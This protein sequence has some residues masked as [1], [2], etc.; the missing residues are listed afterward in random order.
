MRQQLSID[1]VASGRLQPPQPRNF[2][3][4][5]SVEPPRTERPDASPQIAVSPQPLPAVPPVMQRERPTLLQLRTAEQLF[6]SDLSLEILDRDDFGPPLDGSIA[7]VSSATDTEASVDYIRRLFPDVTDDYV[8]NLL[9]N[10]SLYDAVNILAEESIRGHASPPENTSQYA[11]SLTASTVQVQLSPEQQI[12]AP[13]LDGIRNQ[14][15]NLTTAR[16]VS[17]ST[18]NRSSVSASNSISE[19]QGV[20]RTAV[21]QVLEIFPSITESRAMELL[22]EHSV[23]TAIAILISETND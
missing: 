9:K 20:T 15:Q 2:D 18:T 17:D 22:R 3:E 1:M 13:P 21:D 8:I 16:R 6:V 11:P 7:S 14:R 5:L 12:A 19:R 10:R 4:S 23:N